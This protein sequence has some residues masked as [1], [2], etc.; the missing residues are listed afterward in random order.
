MTIDTILEQLVSS[1]QPKVGKLVFTRESINKA[2][3]A[4][5]LEIRAARIDE[6]S[7]IVDKQRIIDSDGAFTT[8]ETRI[9]H[10]L[11]LQQPNTRGSE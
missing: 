5:A 8:V 3:Q 11:N 4:I 6:L 2:K 10:L 7:K 1:G 9:R